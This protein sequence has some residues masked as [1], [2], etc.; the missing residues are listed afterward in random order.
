MFF[1]YQ[2]FPK[3]TVFCTDAGYNF[4]IK[5]KNDKIKIKSASGFVHQDKILAKVKNTENGY[6]FDFPLWTPSNLN[7]P[8]KYHT[9][10]LDYSEA[11][12]LYHLL[13][14]LYDF[15]KSTEGEVIADKPRK[16][17]E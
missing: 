12:F 15:D 14:Y 3:R 16:T 5:G 4:E 7:D 11:H 8:P 9:V 10:E 13:K 17:K 6:I 1:S 2:K